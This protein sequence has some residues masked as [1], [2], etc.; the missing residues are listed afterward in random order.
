MVHMHKHGILL[1]PEGVYTTLHNGVT[2]TL[3]QTTREPLS[4]NRR[5]RELIAL[6][7]RH[8]LNRFLDALLAH[9]EM[10][11]RHQ[12]RSEHIDRCFEKIWTRFAIDKHDEFLIE[13]ANGRQEYLEQIE[14]VKICEG[15]CG[16][17][18]NDDDRRWNG[19]D[20][21]ICRECKAEQV[22]F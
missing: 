13:M 19:T 4:L 15:D 16:D 6:M 10:V 14:G 22:G 11:E 3:S 18:I 2:M 9:T 8:E 17:E 1:V 7:P 5:T 21:T 20:T 12:E